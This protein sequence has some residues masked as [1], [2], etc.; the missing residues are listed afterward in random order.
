MSK[1]LHSDQQLLLDW[2]KNV[3]QLFNGEMCY[4]V[5]SSELKST[6]RDI[7]VR[8]MLGIKEFKKLSRVVNIDRLNLAISLWGQKVTGLPIDFQIQDKEYANKNH[9]GPRSAIGIGIV[10][11]GDGYDPL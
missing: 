1:L 2:A 6:Y 3:V 5:G 4:Q 11:K 10:A 9:S 8:T 7:D